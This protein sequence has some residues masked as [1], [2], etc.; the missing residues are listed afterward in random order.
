MS[1]KRKRGIS[2][3]TFLGAM[4]AAAVNAVAD[5]TE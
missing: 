4:T 1:R 2:R 5:E 3:R